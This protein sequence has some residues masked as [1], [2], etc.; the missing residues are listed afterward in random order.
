VAYSH[1]SQRKWLLWY[2]SSIYRLSRIYQDAI[3]ALDSLDKN[4]EALMS[5]V[6]YLAVIGIGPEQCVALLGTT[7]SAALDQN[8]FAVEQALARANL[9]NTQSTT[10]LQA[11][12]L[13]VS[14]LRNQ[15]DSRTTWSLTALLFHI[16][17]TIAG[18]ELAPRGRPVQPAALRDRDASPPIVADLHSRQ[19]FIS[20][21]RL[22]AYRT[23]RRG[24]LRHTPLQHSL[25]PACQRQRP[26]S[27]HDGGAC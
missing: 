20:V 4:T 22:R 17:Q 23:R 9:P 10:L 1:Y 2:A 16:A 21:P 19:P 24:L 13:F 8:R 26:P 6:Y 12:V 5:S 3:A 27:R 18:H 14:A 7:R 25:A 15:D 11:A